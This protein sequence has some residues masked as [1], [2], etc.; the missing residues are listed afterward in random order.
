M[1]GCLT[2]T[3]KDMSDPIKLFSVWR[4]SW[5]VPPNSRPGSSSSE[6]GIHLA[7]QFTA[8]M[9]H[10]G[11]AMPCFWSHHLISKANMRGMKGR[12]H[13][14]WGSTWSSG[15]FSP[16]F[17]SWQHWKLTW[18]L[19][20]CSSSLCLLSSSWPLPILLPRNIPRK[21]FKS[22]RPGVRSLLFV[23]QL[24]SMQGLQG[25]WCPRQ[26]GSGSLWARFPF[27]P[28]EPHPEDKTGRT[29]E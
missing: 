15:V 20:C 14:P 22:T 12:I 24:L 26:L 29:G 28:P 13:S 17:F 19:S 7:A 3:P 2:R 4:S 21:V 6:S 8:L 5:A 9:Q 18:L 16:S 23:L 25:W 27:N 10:F 1:I 11:W